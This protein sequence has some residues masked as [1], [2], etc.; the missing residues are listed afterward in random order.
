M[1]KGADRT[2]PFCYPWNEGG[3]SV[4]D[5]PNERRS[6]CFGTGIHTI[7]SHGKE[8]E[9]QTGTGIGTGDA[10]TAGANKGMTRAIWFAEPAREGRPR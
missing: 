1:T 6:G 8:N 2:A 10:K 7:R 4:G 5:E 9:R 3:S